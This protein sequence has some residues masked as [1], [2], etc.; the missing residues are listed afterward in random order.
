[1]Q[2]NLHILAHHCDI[3]LSERRGRKVTVLVADQGECV[4]L[5]AETGASVS[6]GS[7][8]GWPSVVVERV[9]SGGHFDIIDESKVGQIVDCIFD[10]IGPERDRP[11]FFSSA[12]GSPY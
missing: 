11:V 4:D 6:S 12:S 5:S 2:A 9:F 7:R 3:D 1:M 8:L 10:T